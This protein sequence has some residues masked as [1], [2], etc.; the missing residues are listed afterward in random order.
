MFQRDSVPLAH[1]LESVEPQASAKYLAFETLLDPVR[2]PGQLTDVLEWP[3]VE[4]LRLD[5]AMSPL[6]I[7][8]TGLYGKMLPPQEGAP[9]RLA[10]PWKYGFKGIK[11]DVRQ[12]LAFAGVLAVLL[13]SR[14]GRNQLEQMQ[15]TRHSVRPKA[16][17]VTERPSVVPSGIR[18]P[19]VRE[20]S[21]EEQVANK[22]QW[23]GQLKV[24]SVVQE[25][26]DVKTFRLM[27]PDGSSL[28][29]G[30]AAKQFI[31]LQ[32]TIDGKRV[33]RS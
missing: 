15:K 23:K 26:P 17:P 14:F 1:I 16:L 24:A 3:Y 11:S 30:Y 2:M 32:L 12:P 28:P 29:F 27:H 31:N 18:R 7:L 22:R 5:E 9:F 25:T 13:G 4:G 10:V 6:A 8:A 33:N 20:S 21:E 19:A